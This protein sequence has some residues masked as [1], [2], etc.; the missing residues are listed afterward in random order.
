MATDPT[1]TRQLRALTRPFRAEYVHGNPGG[2]GSYVSHAMVTQA[3]LAAVGP[4]GWRIAEVLRGD[5]RAIPAD[6]SASSARG[7]EGRPPLVDAVVGAVGELTVTVD[8]R[9]VVVQEAGDCEDPHNWPHDG[10][11]LKDASSDAFKRCAMRLGLGLHL[12]TKDQDDY[13]LH[14][15][16]VARHNRQSQGEGNEGDE[17]VPGTEGDE[18]PPGSRDQYEAEVDSTGQPY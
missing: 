9:R 7:R 5:V 4:F 10:A 2:G 18:T 17:A 3:L 13:L 16:L 1:N 12:W 11:R 6:P 14:G 8:G 15:A